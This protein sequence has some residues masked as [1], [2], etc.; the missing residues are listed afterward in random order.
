MRERD[1]DAAN[2]TRHTD[3]GSPV[4]RNPSLPFA[5]R[6]ARRNA[7]PISI[8][9]RRSRSFACSF[10]RAA[11]AVAL[12]VCSCRVRR[13]LCLPVPSLAHIHA[14]T[15]LLTSRTLLGFTAVDSTRLVFHYS[16]HRRLCP[17]LPCICSCAIHMRECVLCVTHAELGYFRPPVTRLSCH[18]HDA[19]AASHVRN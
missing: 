15:Q 3:I 4:Q 17:A 1:R 8:S 9:V 18:I 2:E 5:A 16:S 10:R 14:T 12:R 19:H 13:S 11:F 6:L 7:M